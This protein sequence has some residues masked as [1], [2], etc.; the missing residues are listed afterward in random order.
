MRFCNRR[1]GHLPLSR[2]YRS[3]FTGTLLKS[4]GHRRR[5][6]RLS[7]QPTQYIPS[8]GASMASISHTESRT[9]KYSPMASTFTPQSAQLKRHCH[10][11]RLI[12]RSRARG[13][14]VF[15]RPAIRLPAARPAR[16]RTRASAALPKSGSSQFHLLGAL[17]QLA[18]VG[19]IA[20][21]V[22]TQWYKRMP[23]IVLVC[24]DVY[25]APACIRI[26]LLSAALTSEHQSSRCVS[27]SMAQI[28]A[29]RATHAMK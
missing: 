2:Q 8:I 3:P 13:E 4:P 17:I 23:L 12:R 27:C 14:G 20:V 21:A 7:K 26:D 16:L 6:I 25:S 18:L 22:A 24:G 10:R 15:T 19:S 29:T 11:S 1:E 28:A 5:F 9:T